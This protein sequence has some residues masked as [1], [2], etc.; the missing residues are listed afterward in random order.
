MFTDEIEITFKAGDG[1]PGRVSFFPGK[2]SG[3]DG[4]N[5]GFGGD[6]FVKASRLI[7]NLNNFVG[8][9]EICAEDGV[10]GGRNNRAGAKGADLEISLPIASLLIDTDS[11]EEIELIGEDKKILVCIGGKGGKGNAEFKSSSNTTPM[12]A[13]KGLLG[14]KRHFKIIV[15]MIADFGLI[16]LPNAGK[17]S[18]LNELTSANVKVADYP[19]TTL[20]PNLGELNGKIIADIPGLIEGASSGRGLGINFLK[21]IEK[22]KLLLHCI[23]SESE[24]VVSDYKVIMQELEGFNLDL[25]KKKQIILLTKLDLFVKYPFL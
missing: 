3:P 16:G 25:V 9:H 11:Q 6:L 12:Y 22:V 15:R 4:G 18:L 1:G 17:S 5:G 2:H 8:K 19:F 7:T 21:H 13:Q 24:D 23:S 10:G 14:Q 20:E